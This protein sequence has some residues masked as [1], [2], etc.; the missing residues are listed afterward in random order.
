M[1]VTSI[2]LDS[3]H[4]RC[5]G[6]DTSLNLRWSAIKTS[7]QSIE[8]E[9]DIKRGADVAGIGR[10]VINSKAP[11]FFLSNLFDLPDHIFPCTRLNNR[12]MLC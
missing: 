9:I 5:V 7:K 2:Y 8:S 4:K 1:K 11:A 10:L 3:N 6:Y 12:L